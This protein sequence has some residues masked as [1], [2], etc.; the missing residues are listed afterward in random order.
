VENSDIEIAGI[1]RDR[2]DRAILGSGD[3]VTR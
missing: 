2:R 1:A 3:R